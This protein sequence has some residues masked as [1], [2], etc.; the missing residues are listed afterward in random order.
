[1]QFCERSHDHEATY[2]AVKTGR[3]V[4]TPW[5]DKENTG[6][7]FHIDSANV[8]RTELFKLFYMAKLPSTD[9]EAV[10]RHGML[11]DIPMT[12]SG[13]AIPFLLPSREK[14]KTLEAVIVNVG[15]N[16]IL[17]VERRI[18]PKEEDKTG[19]LS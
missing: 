7:E 11:F 5:T 15:Y 18:G 10:W 17:V 6:Q 13:R 12:E 19:H 9:R 2:G 8:M 16:E 1:M 14:E 4:V 3:R